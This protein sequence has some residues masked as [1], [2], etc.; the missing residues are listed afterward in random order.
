MFSRV[1]CIDQVFVLDHLNPEKLRASKIAKAELERLEGISMNKNPTA[2]HQISHLNQI[3]IASL[4]C[5]GLH[6]HLKDLIVDPKL[7][8]ADII[9]LQETLL[10]QRHEIP[11]FDS[12]T[13]QI[14]GRGRGKGVGTL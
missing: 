12:F 4:N 5:A 7:K 11:N 14:A 1:Q 2:W 6:P 13:L 8:E 10:D 9:A 3:K